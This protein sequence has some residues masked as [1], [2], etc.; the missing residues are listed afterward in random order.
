[1]VLA[2]HIALTNSVYLQA[3]QA[4]LCTCCQLVDIALKRP[5]FLKYQQLVIPNMKGSWATLAHADLEQDP[6]TEWLLAAEHE[7]QIWASSDWRAG[8]HWKQLVRGIL[9]MYCILSITTQRLKWDSEKEADKWEAHEA[10]T[11][12]NHIS[13]VWCKMLK[14]VYKYAILTVKHITELSFI[15]E[16]H[17]S[18]SN[19]KSNTALYP[20]SALVS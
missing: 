17:K 4:T 5:L 18:W 12:C 13:V 19:V 11:C 16:P 3:H 15:C 6:S 1:M 9:F 14:T 10:K 7:S 2:C 20:V 8:S